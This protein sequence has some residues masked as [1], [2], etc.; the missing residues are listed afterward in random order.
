MKRWIRAWGATALAWAL[1]LV[2]GGAAIAGAAGNSHSNKQGPKTT[3]THSPDAS[4]SESPEPSE[5]P[6]AESS[7]NTDTHGACVSHW[8]HEAQTQGLHGRSFGQ[9]VSGVARSGDT[10]ATCDESAALTKALNDQKNAPTTHG[11][12]NG[13]APDTSG[14]D[15]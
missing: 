14:S 1:V 15:D 3:V 4:E 7:A 13:H 9:F 12:G 5:T 10:G 6:K 11:R 2:L 8:V